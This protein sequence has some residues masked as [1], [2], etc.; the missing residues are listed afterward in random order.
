MVL[1]VNDLV[2]LVE[3]TNKLNFQNHLLLYSIDVGGHWTSF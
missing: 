2:I 3:V 1:G